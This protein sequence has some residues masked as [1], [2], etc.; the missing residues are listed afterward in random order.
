M[1]K[2]SSC[3]GPIE[4]GKCSYCGATYASIPATA[5]EQ[6]TVTRRTTTTTHVV[7]NQ[8]TPVYTGQNDPPLKNRWTAFFLCLFLGYFGAHNF[9]AGKI[10]MGFL[11]L[12]TA[13]LLGIGW[14]V[15]IIRILTGGYLDKWGRRLQE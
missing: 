10:G 6:E 2:C 9:Y 1:D 15:D 11:Y 8:G 7:V 3:G 12:F 13:G 14:I 4:Q 5:P